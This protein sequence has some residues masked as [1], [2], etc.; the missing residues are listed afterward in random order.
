MWIR[1]REKGFFA[2]GERMFST[3]FCFCGSRQEKN[4]KSGTV[5]NITIPA[6]KS[7]QRRAIFK[8]GIFH[9]GKSG[10]VNSN[11]GGYIKTR[12]LSLAAMIC[13]NTDSI[14]GIP[15]SGPADRPCL[16]SS[17]HPE[18]EISHDIAASGPRIRA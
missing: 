18:N 1:E 5:I 3:I 11:C 14:F 4:K 13:Y 9:N 8:I 10:G 2:P 15:Y 17:A 6:L 7:Y 16:S 12:A